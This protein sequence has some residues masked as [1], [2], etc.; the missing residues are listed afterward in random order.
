[1]KQQSI[2]RQT[3]ACANNKHTYEVERDDRSVTI[4]FRDGNGR[5]ER[6][7]KLACNTGVFRDISELSVV[8][9]ESLFLRTYHER[10]SSIYDEP[11]TSK[12]KHVLPDGR[13]EVQIRGK[14]FEDCYILEKP[15]VPQNQPLYPELWEAIIHVPN[16]RHD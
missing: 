8:V 1:M 14:K 16:P 15:F 6:T 2:C 12:C 5:L 3:I 10:G 7:E 4:K 11:G 13:T 9:F